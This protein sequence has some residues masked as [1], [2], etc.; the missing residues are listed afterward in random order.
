MRKRFYFYL[1]IFILINIPTLIVNLR[2]FYKWGSWFAH[3]PV[4]V[5]EIVFYRLFRIADFIANTVVFIMPIS[6]LLSTL[7]AF[8]I[9]KYLNTN[10]I[11]GKK[12]FLLIL[13]IMLIFLIS[14]MSF[15]TIMF[16]PIHWI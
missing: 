5:R 9:I 4:G 16:L 12:R 2:G 11:Q 1:T 7:M 3:D 8:Q 14:L 6:I 10:Q 15:S 13:F